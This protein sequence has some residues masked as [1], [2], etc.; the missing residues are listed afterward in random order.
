MNESVAI[1]SIHTLL[2]LK[3]KES[4]NQGQK[5]WPYGSPWGLN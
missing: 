4:G 1:F 5:L 2:G 3:M